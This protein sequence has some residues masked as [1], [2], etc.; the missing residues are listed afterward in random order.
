M[1][2]PSRSTILSALHF[3]LFRSSAAIN[4]D[5]PEA[6]H[7]ISYAFNDRAATF[8]FSGSASFSG[9]ASWQSGEVFAVRRALAHIET[10]LNV[11][12]VEVSATTNPDMDFAFAA[13]DDG[14]AGQ[15]GW[16]AE[17]S[18]S[19]I[20]AVDSFAVFDRDFDI[21]SDRHAVVLHEIGH[22][23]GLRHSFD[24][25]LLPDR[26]DTNKWT[27]MAYDPHPGSGAGS[28]AMAVFDVLALQEIWGAA[29]H[30]GG[31]T[32]YTGPRTATTDTIWDTGGWDLFD[33]SARP[34]RVKLDLREGEYSRFGAH[35]E[36]VAVAF[37]TVIE[38]S[39]G[40]SGN[41]RLAGNPADNTIRGNA[42]DDMLNG[43]QG[44]DTLLAGAGD[45]RV[46]GGYGQDTINGGP[47]DDILRGGGGADTFIFTSGHDD[48]RDFETD[49][50]R[51]RVEGHGTLEAVLARS[52][53]RG[54]DIWFDFG[55]GDVLVVHDTTRADLADGDLF[56]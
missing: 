54:D 12:F 2:I 19:R 11:D 42:G 37:G 49:R 23:L 51:I 28:D 27:T 39:A 15:G 3:P 47:G 52:E 40:G 26:F 16:K 31:N 18:G 22:A 29:S 48:I 24:S 6:R 20:E 4:G 14:I 10:F 53:Q 56:V 30:N 34:H 13:L 50:D 7:L 41:D 21:V 35:Y 1:A 25:D 38:A 32:T 43:K 33:A 36:D 8:E 9:F 44:N 45:D 5:A 17:T 55:G 46:R